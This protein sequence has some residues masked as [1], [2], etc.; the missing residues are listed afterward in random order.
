M[1]ERCVTSA[2]AS[3]MTG[4]ITHN[5]HP[6]SCSVLAINHCSDLD[7]KVADAFQ[8]YLEERGMDKKLAKFIQACMIDKEQRE[9]QLWM[10]NISSFLAK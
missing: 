3:V 2:D 8:E 7:E 4:A 10:A 5:G 6:F 9:Y 1:S